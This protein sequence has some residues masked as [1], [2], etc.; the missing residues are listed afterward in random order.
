M[1]SATKT[2]TWLPTK[3][4]HLYRHHSGIYYVR[5]GH[6]SWRSL[7]TKLLNIAIVERDKLIQAERARMEM[8]PD[9]IRIEDFSMAAMQT[10][11]M[12]QIEEDVSLKPSTKIC[13]VGKTDQEEQKQMGRWLRRSGRIPC[14]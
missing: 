2:K 14:L 8:M 12:R 4:E 5:L 11:R 3:H 7:R 13:S 10:L 1:R 9:S 6:R